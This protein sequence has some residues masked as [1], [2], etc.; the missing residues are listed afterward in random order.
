MHPADQGSR[1][2][3]IAE[4]GHRAAA[5]L[6]QKIVLQRRFVD[7]VLGELLRE[8][9]VVGEGEG[10]QRVVDQLAQAVIVPGGVVP[11]SVQPHGQ[12]HHK[13]A[14]VAVVVP[15]HPLAA[16]GAFQISGGIFIRLG[17]SKQKQPGAPPGNVRQIFLQ[18]DPP[19]GGVTFIAHF[20]PPTFI[21]STAL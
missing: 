20:A 9:L 6:R 18:Q 16:Q 15:S 10:I 17:A 8:S 4:G 21:F 2:A 14:G 19:H 11:L 13:P 5:Y 7:P 3:A 1:G 12:T